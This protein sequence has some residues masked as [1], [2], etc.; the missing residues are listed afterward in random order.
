MHSSGVKLENEKKETQSFDQLK[1]LKK[2]YIKSFDMVVVNLYPFEKTS[3][4]DNLIAEY[5]SSFPKPGLSEFFT[6]LA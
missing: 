5:F 2:Y 6:S 3:R 4:Y 1:E